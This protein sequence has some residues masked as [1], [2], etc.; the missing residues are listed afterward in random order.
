MLQTARHV[1][2]NPL[3]ETAGESGERA[4]AI[5]LGCSKNSSVWQ[6]VMAGF[7]NCRPVEQ[8]LEAGGKQKG[9]A[10]GDK[11][12]PHDE[13][14]AHAEEHAKS[15]L[16]FFVRITGGDNLGWRSA[17]QQCAEKSPKRGEPIANIGSRLPKE[18]KARA[19]DQKANHGEQLRHARPRVRRNE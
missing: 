16:A 19:D 4:V 1:H 15:A 2:E 8:L 3:Y 6:T 18:I 14:E 17:L 10:D 5:L 13:G 9:E 7:G 11:D 12:G